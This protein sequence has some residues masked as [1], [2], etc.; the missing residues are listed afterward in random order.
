MLAV[1]LVVVV[2]LI[3][4]F[5]LFD[6]VYTGYLWF[7]SVGFS[8]VY[9]TRLATQISLFLSFGAVM[10]LAVG[11]NIWLAYRFRPPL[12]GISL[13]QQA[14][15]RYRLALSPYLRWI[16]TAA[17]LAVGLIAG[18]SAISG[19]RTY[20][21]WANAVPFGT[22]DAQ[23]HRDIGFYVFTLPWL[24]HVQGFVLAVVIVSL[25]ATLTTQYLYA[26]I[27]LTP[28]NPNAVRGPG[29][30]ATRAAQVHISILLGCLVL[31]KA[32]AYWL[33]RYALTVQPSSITAGWAGPTYK[34][35]HAVLPAKSILLVIAILC[36]V[37]FFGNAIR[38]IAQRHTPEINRGGHPW[39]VP[40]LA[41]SLMVLAAVVIGGVYPLVVQQLSVNP[42]QAT[43]EA[44]YIQK[45]I[46]ATRAA[47]S[48]DDVSV[49]PY[50]AKT[51]V[52]AGQL[53]TDA[54][55][56]T[57]IR[58]MDP[59]VISATFDQTDQIRGF[60]TFPDDLS[61]DR[62]TIGGK[63]QDAVVAVRGLDL[64]GIAA[65]QRN[66][67]N[68]HLKYTHG[69]GIV[70]AKGNSSGG[71][72]EPDYLEA[73][74]PSGG[75]LGTFEQRVYFGEGLPDYS[76]VGGPAGSTP[77]EFDYPDRS[78]TQEH[79]T[80]YTGKGGVPIG[81]FFNKLLYATKFQEPKIL[82]SNGVNADSRIMDDRDPKQRVQAVAP[83]LT[84]DGSTYPVVA[85]G[86]LLWVVDGYTTTAAYPYSTTT[87]LSDVTQDSQSSSARDP[88]N[89]GT[90][91]Y[92]RNSVKATVDAYDGTVTLYAWD[93]SDPILKAWE[94]AFPGTVQPKSAISPDLMA[95]LRYPS[96][97][98]KAQ[99]DIL[100]RY[101]VTTAAEFFTGS[102]FWS[103]PDDPTKVGETSPQPPYYLTLQMPG[104]SAPSFS[105]T[106]TLV[107]AKRSNLAA[108]VA[109][110]SD[111]GPD[112][113]KIRVLE[114][115]A[116]TAIPG[117]GQVQNN[118]RADND[119]SQKMNSLKIGGNTTVVEGNLLTLPVGGGLLYVEP[120][121][122]QATSGTSYP[123]LQQLLVSFGGDITIAPTL[124]EALDEVF[125]GD[126]GATTGETAQG[127]PTGPT[128]APGT[129]GSATTPPTD[130]QLA[131]ALKEASDA[132]AAAAAALA[133][134]PPDW[135]G[136]GQAEDRLAKALVRAAAL[137]GGQA[138]PSAAPSGAPATP[139]SPVGTASS[140]PPPTSS[141]APP[142]PTPSSPTA[143]S[144][145]AVP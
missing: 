14:L 94:R 126:S 131:A 44:P 46:E 77:A 144:S 56:V 61:V 55:T 112:Y 101:H 119:V 5:L 71:N 92:I 134:T 113:G 127:P 72:G 12:T 140:A 98:F 19:W 68:D 53:A 96:D 73:G 124:Q 33:D 58:I 35:V 125:Q 116:D 57:Q 93:D 145:S 120:I 9:R 43:K 78:A 21:L 121:Y 27:S 102:S 104:Q 89:A 49:T 60:Y 95:H 13:E 15:D 74:L 11:A 17:T 22:T 80:T 67:V 30:R 38:L 138:A 91:N 3:A 66:W 137:A 64:S 75:E 141:A 50:A 34:D 18:S 110:D 128:T 135:I 84:I 122:A 87:Q 63:S 133:Q 69:Y 117:P 39:A 88:L 100:S 7:K 114:L 142:P 136:F 29:R 109:V 70:A 118:F 115:P 79:N 31:V 105:L 76:I 97:M 40:A 103:V 132:Q 16:H 41:V 106:S 59:S 36:A 139:P 23:F 32:S 86:R 10:A 24:R 99:R 143:P 6:T 82:L 8:S 37:L 45:N 2:A 83:W 42:S 65:S 47:Y 90:V 81:S 123:V 54:S 26:G 129:T 130:Q 1:T 62:Y 85:D 28:P 25:L 20:L 51:D 108:F 4:G 48:L 111:P 107:P 52:S